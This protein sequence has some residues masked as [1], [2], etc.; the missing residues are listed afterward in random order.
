M[1]NKLKT[2][3]H[4]SISRKEL[5]AAA[6]RSR[7]GQT[8]EGETNERQESAP[9]GRGSACR[10]THIALRAGGV[11]AG[12]PEHPSLSRGADTCRQPEQV[13]FPRGELRGP[14]WEREPFALFRPGPFCICAALRLNPPTV[15]LA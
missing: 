1:Q 13:I 9:T 4:P 11:E 3:T 2:R 6:A 14:R 8:D 15:S 7:S 5:E 10:T 12:G